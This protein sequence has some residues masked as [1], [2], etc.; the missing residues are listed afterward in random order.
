VKLGVLA[1]GRLK[2]GPERDLVERYA[3]RMAAVGKPLGLTFAL[4]EVGESRARQAAARMDQEGEALLDCVGKGLLVAF[5][6]HGG[7]MDSGRFAER[8]AAWRDAGNAELHCVIGGP[9]GLSK[10]ILDQA[11]LKLSFGAMTL[12]H[13][14]ARILVV[15]QLYRAMTILSGHPY[16]RA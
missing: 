2:A 3:A 15:E 4:R 1:V 9:D 10:R 16:H 12:P 11:A 8:I 14:L 6:E 13:Q 7:S 5:D